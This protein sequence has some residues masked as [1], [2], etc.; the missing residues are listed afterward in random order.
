MV[1]IAALL[2]LAEE[3]PGSLALGGDKLRGPKW[4]LAALAGGVAGALGAHLYA[5]SQPEPEAAPEEPAEQP[6]DGTAATAPH[7]A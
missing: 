3:G 5:E 2:L 1:I 6:T 4:A 7:T